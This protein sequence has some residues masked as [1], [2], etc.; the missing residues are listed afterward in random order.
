[1]IA[2]YQ[3]R[4]ERLAA[5]AASTSDPKERSRYQ[6]EKEICDRMVSILQNIHEKYKENNK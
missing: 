6:Q 1:M 5:L 3:R 4:A 2:S